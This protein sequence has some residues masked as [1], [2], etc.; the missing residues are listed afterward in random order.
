ML[1][2]GRGKRLRRKTELNKRLDVPGQQVVVKLVDLRPVVDG[3]SVFDLHRSQHVMK[4]RMKA[5]VAKAEFIHSELEL[6]LA[7]IANQRA[8]IIGSN[9]Q[10]EESIYRAGGIVDV[11]DNLAR[12]A[13]LGSNRG[14]KDNRAE[15]K[16]EYK[17]CQ[18][19]EHERCTAYLA[20]ICR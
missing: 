12:E 10:I 4:D 18:W 3:F 9:R 17:S 19:V 8:R 13:L 6:R 16:D 5:D 14:G 2:C 15:D 1:F 20:S 11:R 7:V